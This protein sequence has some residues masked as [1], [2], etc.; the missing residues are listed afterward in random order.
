MMQEDLERLKVLCRLD[1]TTLS[2]TDLNSTSDE[3]SD[4]LHREDDRRRLSSLNN[5][6]I[7]EIY[8]QIKFLFDKVWEPT[9]QRQREDF[10]KWSNTYLLSLKT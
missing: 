5:Q 2:E 6:E 4:I 9:I 1:V 7:R 3:L 8:L 10:A